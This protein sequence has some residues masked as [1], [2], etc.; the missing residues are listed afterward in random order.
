MSMFSLDLKAWKIECFSFRFNRKYPSVVAKGINKGYIIFKT[1][2]GSQMRGFPQIC[3]DDKF[4]RRVNR[5][6]SVRW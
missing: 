3:E 4:Q 1:S 6:R 5:N 2:I